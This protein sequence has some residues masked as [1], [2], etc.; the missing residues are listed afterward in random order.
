VQLGGSRNRPSLNSS[1]ILVRALL[2]CSFRLR[3]LPCGILKELLSENSSQLQS[4]VLDSEI[5]VDSEGRTIVASG[6]SQAENHAKQK[7]RFAE[8]MCSH[9]EV[10]SLLEYLSRPYDL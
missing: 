6:L 8:F 9:H 3:N 2:I 5:S 4:Q 1:V 7:P 10:R